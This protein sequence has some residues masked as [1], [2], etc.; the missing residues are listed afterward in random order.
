MN[1]IKRTLKTIWNCFQNWV[2]GPVEAEEPRF[3]IVK[4]QAVALDRWG[5]NLKDVYFKDVRGARFIYFDRHSWN[6][7]R[8]GSEK[9]TNYARLVNKEGFMYAIFDTKRLAYL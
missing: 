6:V 5:L 3:A 1:T 9:D 4:G 8:F 7:V 2:D